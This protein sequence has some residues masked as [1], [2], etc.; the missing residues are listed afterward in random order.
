MENELEILTKQNEQVIKKVDDL[1]KF[2]TKKETFLSKLQKLISNFWVVFILICLLVIDI[3]FHI[4]HS[5]FDSQNL[6]LGF[7]GILATFIVVSNYMQVK[8]IEKVFDKKNIELQS[9]ID[10]KIRIIESETLKIQNEVWA[11]LVESL[12]IQAISQPKMFCNPNAYLVGID[13]L[14]IAMEHHTINL[15]STIKD[16]LEKF[17]DGRNIEIDSERLTELNFL[18]TKNYNIDKRVFNKFRDF[19]KNNLVLYDLKE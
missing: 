16:F 2:L 11:N 3:A 13:A 8:E 15:E 6:V 17:S 18:V 1:S 5:V 12:L 10:E 9:K 7:V 4:S 19:V 14:I